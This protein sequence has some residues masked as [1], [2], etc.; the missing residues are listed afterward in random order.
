MK[1]IISTILIFASQIS[2]SFAQTNP[3]DVL[4]EPINISDLIGVQSFA[5]GQYN[6][7]L[8]VVGGRL[9][10]LHRRQP[11]AA[12]D[13]AG[14]NGNLIVIDP[15]ASQQW[16]APLTSLS[17]NLQEQLSSTNM[18]FYQSDSILYCLGGY[19]YN[20]LAA[21]HI[22]YENLTAINVPLVIN[23]IINGFTFNTFIRQITDSEFAVTGGRLDKI[24][25]TYYLVGGQKFTGEYNPMGGPTFTQEY[26]NQIRKF[27]IDDNGT[28]ISIIHLPSITDAVNL[29]RRDYNVMPQIMPNGDEGITAFSGV[30][31]TT[32]DV[33]YLNCVNIESS[34]YCTSSKQ[35][36]LKR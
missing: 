29:H 25:N 20:N 1:V 33:P 9:D 16:T 23:A 19:G 18:E 28:S 21:D 5:Y 3:F 6:G 17:S 8:L 36:E 27:T 34:G 14:E 32:A 35:S 4:L 12:F 31:Q 2:V 22:T 11:F 24:D 7:K 13:E 10:G 26:T 15:V 30:F